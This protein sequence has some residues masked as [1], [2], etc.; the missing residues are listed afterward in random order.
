MRATESKDPNLIC[1][2]TSAVS[3]GELIAT[4]VPPAGSSRGWPFNQERRHPL[5]NRRRVARETQTLAESEP[6]LAKC[7][8]KGK[9]GRDRTDTSSFI[10]GQ[11]RLTRAT[12]VPGS[13]ELYRGNFLALDNE[14]LKPAGMAGAA[15]MVNAPFTRAHPD[16]THPRRG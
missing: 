4:P 15:H 5:E 16:E 1:L 10:P 12:E 3:R 11:Q 6:G 7:E 8:C 9:V 13:H 2:R 14:V